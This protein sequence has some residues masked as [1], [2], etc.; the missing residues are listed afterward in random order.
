MVE[1]AIEFLYF[2]FGD[3]FGVIF[4]FDHHDEVILV[5]YKIAASFGLVAIFN[6]GF[7]EESVEAFVSDGFADLSEDGGILRFFE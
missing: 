1:I 6:F 5:K 7:W 3:I 4:S 2:G